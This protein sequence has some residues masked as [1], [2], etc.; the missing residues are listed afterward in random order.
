MT[1]LPYLLE[2]EPRQWLE[3]VKEAARELE[4]ELV[5][6]LDENEGAPE[7]A[8][9]MQT[10][11]EPYCIDPEDPTADELRAQLKA[12]YVF[13]GQEEGGQWFR[14]E[15]SDD[16]HWWVAGEDSHEEPGQAHRALA[17][18]IV[19]SVDWGDPERAEDRAETQRAK[20]VIMEPFLEAVDEA[21]GGEASAADVRDAL[22]QFV[23]SCLPSDEEVAVEDKSPD[24]A[25]THLVIRF[26][27]EE[28]GHVLAVS[29][30]DSRAPERLEEVFGV[31]PEFDDGVRLVTDHLRFMWPPFANTKSASSDVVL[32]SEKSEDNLVDYYFAIDRAVSLTLRAL[33]VER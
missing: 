2:M 27:D 8:Q 33:N 25:H 1:K 5:D 31:A 22:V 24:T 9:A 18:R 7:L 23:E 12:G 16:G 19:E 21:G 6:V 32:P 29:P 4:E 10:A 14:L 13:V 26:G 17:R 11:F 3:A 15:R 30:G 28:W 20:R